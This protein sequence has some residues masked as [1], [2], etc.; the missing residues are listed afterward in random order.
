MKRGVILILISVLFLSGCTQFE[1]Q[2][3]KAITQDNAKIVDFEILNRETGELT[4]ASYDFNYGDYTFRLEGIEDLITIS[5]G[6]KGDIIFKNTDIN[7]LPID[8]EYS[9]GH[10]I[11]LKSEPL[12]KF[13]NKAT[14]EAQKITIKE[15]QKKLKDDLKKINENIVVKKEFYKAINGIV[16][17]KKLTNEELNELEKNPNIKRIMPNTGVTA[18]LDQSTGIISSDA[19]WNQGYTGQGTTIGILDTGVDYTHSDLGGCFGSGCKVEGGYDFIN[20]DPDPIDDHGHGTHCAATAAGIDAYGLGLKGVAP[21]ATIYA[22]KVLSSSGGGS[23]ASI[24]AGIEASMD[25]NGDDDFSDHLDVI[26]LSL[27]GS[28]RYY[29]SMA[30]AID[31]ATEIGVTAAIAAG[32]SWDYGKIKTPGIARTAIT[33]G[34]SCKAYNQGGSISWTGEYLPYCRE[35]F[36]IAAFS[37]KGPA[38]VIGES[39]SKP[40][41]VAPGVEICASQHGTYQSSN[42]CKDGDHIAI[43]G[44]SMAT[45]HVAGAAALIKQANPDWTPQQIKTAITLSATELDFGAPGATGSPNTLYQ[46]S[47][48]LNLS[49]TNDLKFSTD[50]S[51]LSVNVEA[52][53]PTGNDNI[54]ISNLGLETLVLDVIVEPANEFFDI[55]EG[56][57]TQHNIMTPEVSTLYVRGENE[58]TLNFNIDATGKSGIFFGKIKLIQNGKPHVIPYTIT[59]LSKVTINIEDR[60]DYIVNPIFSFIVYNSDF[61]SSRK[62]AYLGRDESMV[63]A[64]KG[65]QQYLITATMFG[66]QD[67]EY[68]LYDSV[69]LQENQDKTLNLRIADAKE[70][71]VEGK[72]I[73]GKDLS[74]NQESGYYFSNGIDLVRSRFTSSYPKTGSYKIYV[75]KKPTDFNDEMG[76]F[77]QRKGVESDPT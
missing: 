20:E 17:E 5:M 4:L 30:E 37:S 43:S 2:F 44:T 40:D 12:Y 23:A 6:D 63:G 31:A 54:V 10:I 27:G 16:I 41:I 39:I 53:N 57:T 8:I 59:K 65:E 61:A 15:E 47:G 34:A 22:Y 9:I 46:G 26:S 69:Y 21:D 71:I 64:F 74:S 73:N 1:P 55:K 25:P 28:T 49:G 70:F 36:P 38:I 76:V 32:N 29:D 45:P 66:T 13:H 3:S 77:F 56:I 67:S 58:K 51:S 62:Y 7:S 48:Q 60:Q 19:F 72:S 14:K 68:F 75:S 24:I 42:S 52:G 18:S 35:E 11:E 50:K 33:V